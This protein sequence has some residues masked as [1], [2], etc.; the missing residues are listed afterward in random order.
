MVTSNP[1]TT[2]MDDMFAGELDFEGGGGKRRR[3]QRQRR[4]RIGRVL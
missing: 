3:R 4:R 1:S 2:M